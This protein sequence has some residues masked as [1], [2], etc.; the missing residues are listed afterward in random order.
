MRLIFG[1]P[2]RPWSLVCLN[3]GVRDN[4]LGAG[5]VR[6]EGRHE[7]RGRVRETMTEIMTGPW[8]LPLDIGEIFIG[9]YLLQIM[10]PVSSIPLIQ[11]ILSKFGAFSDYKLNFHKSECFPIHTLAQNITGSSIPP[12]LSKQ[13]FKYLGIKIT[14]TLP[15]MFEANFTPLVA[16]MKSDFQCWS[17]ILPSFFKYVVWCLPVFLP[18]SYFCTLDQEITTFIWVGKVPRISKAILQ[19]PRKTGGLAPPN[20]IHYYWAANI[21]TLVHWL[22]NPGAA[23]CNLEAQSCQSPSLSAP[24][25]SS[26]PLSPSRHSSN[27]LVQSTLKIWMQFLMCIQ[28]L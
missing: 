25:C 5:R 11:S 9:K 6:D 23:W 18:K 7:G 13:G 24:V 3:V 1:G 21:Q 15:S 17:N 16:N 12:H 26:L 14:C 28:N 4:R 10:N 8:N 27:P 20:F 19:K 2:V 22:K